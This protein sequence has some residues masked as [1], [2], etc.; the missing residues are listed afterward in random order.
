M[1]SWIA[2]AFGY[3]L[4]VSAGKAIF[5]EDRPKERVPGR[6]P[7]RPQT[8]EEILADEK[9]YEQEERQLD[10]ADAAAQAAAAARAR[11]AAKPARR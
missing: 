6:E 11:P 9:R 7:V 5:A 10:A 2:T 3:G 8:E 1:S 4:G